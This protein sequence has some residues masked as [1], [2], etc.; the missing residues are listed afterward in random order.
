VGRPDEVNGGG[1]A[2]PESRPARI[3][4]ERELM[5]GPDIGM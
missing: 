4:D 1:P 5:D 3:S 2:R